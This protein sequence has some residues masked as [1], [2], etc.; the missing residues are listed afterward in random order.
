MLRVYGSQL[1]IICIIVFVGPAASTFES[2]IGASPS[3]SP[4]FPAG[5]RGFY[6]YSS[7][8]GSAVLSTHTVS[9]EITLP[10]FASSSLEG[11]FS[12]L[13]FNIFGTPDPQAEMKD[14]SEPPVPGDG[15]TTLMDGMVGTA[16]N[17][18]YVI[19]ESDPATVSNTGSALS[20][21]P[22]PS[23][24]KDAEDASDLYADPFSAV[25][26][27]LEAASSLVTLSEDYQAAP[28]ARYAFGAIG[29]CAA[30]KDEVLSASLGTLCPLF[31]ALDSVFT[32]A[33]EAR[34]RGDVIRGR[35]MCCVCGQPVSIV[36][37]D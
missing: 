3:P 1:C 5:G 17:G 20:I 32:S 29:A 36:S 13:G 14:D 7:F 19:A 30:W 37:L 12:L 26:T 35:M 2:I 23:P 33:K 22:E 11:S 18:T 21:V 24:S 34:V 4:A 16:G 27:D 9:D 15:F 6:E 8:L 28:S 31:S 25:G 10:E